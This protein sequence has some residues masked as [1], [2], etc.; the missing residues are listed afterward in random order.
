[1]R[2]RVCDAVSTK[3][4]IVAER[5]WLPALSDW[6]TCPVAIL[7]P[8]QSKHLVRHGGAA[9]YIVRQD[10]LVVVSV[11]HQLDVLLL[12]LDA[13]DAFQ[14]LLENSPRQL[15]EPALQDMGSGSS[16]VPDLS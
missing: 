1:L 4:V 10:V 15:H 3:G 9:Q 5:K 13:P 6:L 12:R 11:L 14:H 2:N 7:I 8:S 16:K